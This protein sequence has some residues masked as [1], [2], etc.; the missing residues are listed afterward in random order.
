[1]M[2]SNRT[3]KLNFEGHPDASKVKEVSLDTK[4]D[5]GQIELNLHNSNSLSVNTTLSGNH[6]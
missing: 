1:M 4:K 6:Y 3:E 2:V 5:D